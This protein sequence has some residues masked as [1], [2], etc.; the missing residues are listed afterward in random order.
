MKQ[1]KFKMPR[2]LKKGFKKWVS[3]IK[4]IFPDRTNPNVKS[5]HIIEDMFSLY[6]AEN[7]LGKPLFK[8]WIGKD[9][10]TYSEVS[11]KGKMLN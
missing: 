4:G 8:V 3:N 2:K 1:K 9:G 6:K 11:E 5:Q 10:K 7:C